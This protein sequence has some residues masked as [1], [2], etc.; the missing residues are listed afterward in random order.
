SATGGL[1]YTLGGLF[2]NGQ[3]SMLT[4]Y[5]TT[6]GKEVMETWILFGDPSVMIRSKVPTSIAG[7]SSGC[8]TNGTPY[9][10]GATLEGADVAITQNGN[11]VG[12]GVIASGSC[13]LNISGAVSGTATLTVTGYNQLPYT[14]T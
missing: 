1:K 4:N 6:T 7:T 14:T 5:P 11:L 2:Y 9:T 8:F 12:S 10:I 3:Y 13:D